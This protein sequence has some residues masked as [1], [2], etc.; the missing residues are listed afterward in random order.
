MGRGS[1]VFDGWVESSV[2]LDDPLMSPREL[3]LVSRDTDE[4]QLVTEFDYP[5]WRLT[6]Q[7]RTER[8]SKVS[9][10]LDVIVASLAQTPDQSLSV[11]RKEVFSSSISSWAYDQA[12]SRLESEGRVEIYQDPGKAGNHKRVRLLEEPKLQTFE[13]MVNHGSVFDSPF[14]TV[15]SD[16]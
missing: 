7:Y 2:K 8:S 6:T 16:A 3:Q 1:S 5:L 12:K 10:A 14:A 13:N 15:P 4:T 9:H 11:L